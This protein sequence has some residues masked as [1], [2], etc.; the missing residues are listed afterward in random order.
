VEPKI[1]SFS[2][3]CNACVGGKSLKDASRTSS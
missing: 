3:T 1:E 2:R